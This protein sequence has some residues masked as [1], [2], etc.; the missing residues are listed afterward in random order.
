MAYS[1][2]LSP[3]QSITTFPDKNSYVLF[4]KFSGNKVNKVIY[5]YNKVT[6]MLLLLIMLHWNMYRYPLAYVH[7]HIYELRMIKFSLFSNRTPSSL[8]VFCFYKLL[9]KKNSSKLTNIDAFGAGEDCPVIFVSVFSK[10]F[11][12]CICCIQCF[13][14][15]L[16]IPISMKKF[17]FAWIVNY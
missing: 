7:K 8:Y 14:T 17:F 2:P 3:F 9:A 4:S 16:L 12:I 1:A 13:K 15:N 10:W 6:I 11:D 5:L